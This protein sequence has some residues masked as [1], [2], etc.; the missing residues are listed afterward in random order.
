M[1]SSLA[2]TIASSATKTSDGSAPA[3]PPGVEDGDGDEQRSAR[4]DRPEVAGR[5]AREEEPPHPLCEIGLPRDAAL[6]L[7]PSGADQ[8]VADVRLARVGG[9]HVRLPRAL[10]ALQREQQLP[11]AG[12]HRQ[13]L[14][15]MAIPVAAAEVHPAVDAGRVALEHLLDQADAFE[16][17]APVERRDQAEAA[18]QVGHAGLFGRLVLAFRPNGVLDRLSAR[19]Q[20]GVELLVQLRRDR[21]EGARA[22][23]QARDERMMDVLRP[24]AEALVFGFERR[25]QPIRCQAMDAGGGERVASARADGRAARASARSATPR[26]RRS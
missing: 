8:V 4:R 3:V 1:A 15:G 9:P 14:D 16:E 24:L 17:L 5:R 7:P 13:L 12:R 10:D 19:R 2:G 6:E 11:L 26:A 25:G 23:K 18:D 22:L 20:R 21:A